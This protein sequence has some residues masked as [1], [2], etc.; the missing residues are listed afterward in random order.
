[1]A[2]RDF[3]AVYVKP[4]IDYQIIIALL[5]AILNPFG[6]AVASPMGHPASRT[7]DGRLHAALLAK[8]MAHDGFLGMKAVLCLVPDHGIGAVHNLGRG[9]IVAVGGQAMHK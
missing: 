7:S 2:L 8:A 6:I 1:M 4:F 3:N 5:H 9:L